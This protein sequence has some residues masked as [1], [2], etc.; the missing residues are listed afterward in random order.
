MHDITP[1]LRKSLDHQ[2]TASHQS[3]RV[4]AAAAQGRVFEMSQPRDY[5]SDQTADSRLT[6]RQHT[7]DVSRNPRTT[8]GPVR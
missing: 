1:F 8:D 3:F 5:D 6:D 7:L 2:K 4:L